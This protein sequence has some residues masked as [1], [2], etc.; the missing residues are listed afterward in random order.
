MNNEERWQQRFENMDKAYT[1]FQ[2][3]LE[4]YLEDKGNEAERMALIQGFEVVQELSWKTVRNYL[5]NEGYDDLG[6]SK[7]TIRTAFQE[8]LIRNAEVWMEAI[9]LRNETSHTY[10]D[11]VVEEILDFITEEFAEQLQELHEW[12]RLRSKI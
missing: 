5:E 2:R 4:G 3:R 11:S 12:L 9:R 10:D 6:N 7:K 8:E 1:V